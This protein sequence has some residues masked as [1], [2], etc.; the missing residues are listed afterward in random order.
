MPRQT[1]LYIYL[2]GGYATQETFDPKPLSPEEYKGPLQSI[3][4]SIPGVEF[5]EFFKKLPKLQINYL[6]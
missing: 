2:P 1:Q 4:T 3:K 5:N 6:L